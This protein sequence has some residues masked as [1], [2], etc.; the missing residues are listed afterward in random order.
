MTL[1]KTLKETQFSKTVNLSHG[2]KTDR[3]NNQP[4]RKL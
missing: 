1:I 3:T 2:P 4:L